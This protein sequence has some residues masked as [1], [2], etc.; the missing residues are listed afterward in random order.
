MV[1][2][3]QHQESKELPTLI[4]VVVTVNVHTVVLLNASV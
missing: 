1:R 3:A 2:D 4:V